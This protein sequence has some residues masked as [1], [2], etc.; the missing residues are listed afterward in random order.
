MNKLASFH[1]KV[2]ELD[3]EYD[4]DPQFCDSVSIFEFMLTL[5]SLTDLDLIPEPTLIHVPIELEIEPPILNCHIQ[6]MEKEYEIQLFDLD[7]TLEPKS[8]LKPKHDLSNILE[9]VLVPFPFIFEPKST[10]HQLTFR[11][12]TKA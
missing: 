4:P 7:S 5:V 11:C 12:W 10:I 9:S 2:I 1:F 6:L 3:Y 8:T